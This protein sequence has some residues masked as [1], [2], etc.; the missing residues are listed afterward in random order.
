[1][2]TLIGVGLCLMLFVVVSLAVAQSDIYGAIA[3]DSSAGK[4]GWSTGHSTQADAEQAA[5]AKCNSPGCKSI[6]WVKNACAALATTNDLG[7][8]SAWGI[9]KADAEDKAISTC[10]QHNPNKNCQIQCS[11]CTQNV[12]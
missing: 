8:G 4:W 3:F 12:R 5:I 10:K 9:N 6:M 11:P 2:K 7:W 1:M